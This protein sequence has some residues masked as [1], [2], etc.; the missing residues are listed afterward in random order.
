M[1]SHLHM[2]FIKKIMVIFLIVVAILLVATYLFMQRPVFGKNPDTKLLARIQ[3]SPHY[4][5]GSFQNVEPTAV[6]RKEASRTGMIMDLFNK[7]SLVTPPKALPSIKTDLKNLMADKPTIVWF[8]HSSYLIKSNGFVVLVDPVFSGQA[9]P[10]SFFGKSFVGADVYDVNDMPPIDLLVLTHDHYDHLDYKT[11]KQIHPQVK[12]IVT[13]LGVDAHL[14]HWGVPIDK[15]STI[16]WWE[17]KQINNNIKITATPSR[18]FS[19][20]GFTRGKTQWAS[21][22]LS[23]D[24]FSIFIG[25]DSGYDKQFKKIGDTYGPFDI[26]LL[27]CGQY[28]KDW[29]SIHMLPEEVAMAAKD[30]KTKVLMPVHWAKFAL[31]FHN[32]NEPIERLV[33]SASEKNVVLTTPQIGEP[34]VLDKHYPT[35]MWWR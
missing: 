35:S 25:G 13:A 21:F 22:V 26:A 12:H 5:D 28:G 30:L 32:W 15:I 34:V 29:P 9:S 17:S 2:K 8:G 7:P 6:M 33:K 11:I 3:Q 10:V 18:H 20:R 24:G 23:I 19:G 4:K 16:D 1:A 27:E 31:A 14:S